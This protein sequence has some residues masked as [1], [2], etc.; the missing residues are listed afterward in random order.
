[1]AWAN[2]LRKEWYS[3]SVVVP[4]TS[5]TY[6]FGPRFGA[7][8]DGAGWDSFQGCTAWLEGAL[9]SATVEL[10]VPKLSVIAA[11]AR[12]FGELVNDDFVYS[13]QTFT[14]AE[15]M[16][17]WV[18]AGVPCFEIRIKSGGTGGTVVL[19]ATAL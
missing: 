5:G 2:G 16:E 10:W 9:A 17:T 12:S 7:T 6:G 19:N 13:G 15:A 1:M 11:G 8:K 3:Q 14:S 18:L 4:A